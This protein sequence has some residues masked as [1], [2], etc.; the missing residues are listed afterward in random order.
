MNIVTCHSEPARHIPKDEPVIEKPLQAA[1]M[2]IKQAP[3]M[4]MFKRTVIKVTAISNPASPTAPAWLPTGCRAPLIFTF[5]GIVAIGIV[6]VGYL[7][8]FI[9]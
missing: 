5:F 8:N 1:Q 4:T 6:V 2:R 7:F 3:R 9:M